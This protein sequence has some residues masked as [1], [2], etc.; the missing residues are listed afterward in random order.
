MKDGFLLASEESEALSLVQ[1]EFCVQALA[2]GLNHHQPGLGECLGSRRQGG[3]APS[4][5]GL[6]VA[7]P[8]LVA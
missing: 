5:G 4:R 7:Q 1:V 8:G 2:L 6:W 3:V